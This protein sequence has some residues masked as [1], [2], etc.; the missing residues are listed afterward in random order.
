MITLFHCQH[1]WLFF[2]PL[3]T[4]D[5]FEILVVAYFLQKPTKILETTLHKIHIHSDYLYPSEAGG[6]LPIDPSIC[7]F[8]SQ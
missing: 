6:R 2:R 7:A 4:F 1:L 8:R 3:P 5:K